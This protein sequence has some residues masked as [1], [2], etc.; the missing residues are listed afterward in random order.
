MVFGRFFRPG[1]LPFYATLPP[2][3]GRSIITRLRLGNVFLDNRFA[4]VSPSLMF[5]TV[6]QHSGPPVISHADR[7][8]PALWS[9]LFHLL[10]QCPEPDIQLSRSSF[11]SQFVLPLFPNWPTAP[12]YDQVATIILLK[13]DGFHSATLAAASGAF[14]VNVFNICGIPFRE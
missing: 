2:F 1:K 11:I 13:A 14:L 6:C 5:C 12:W 8:S 9:T 4:K 7:D 10:V 3:V